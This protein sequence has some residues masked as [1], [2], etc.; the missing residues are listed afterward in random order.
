[1]LSGVDIK[2]YNGALNQHFR[3]FSPGYHVVLTYLYQESGTV[4]S[5]DMNRVLRKVEA[6][7]ILADEM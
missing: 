5:H 3:R 6:R 1:M 4:C 7:C 2:S